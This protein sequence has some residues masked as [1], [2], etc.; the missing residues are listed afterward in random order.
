MM[1]L[2]TLQEVESEVRALGTR[3]V[4]LT[5]ELQ[6]YTRSVRKRLTAL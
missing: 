2:E 4:V 3:L 6:G 1:E 5:P